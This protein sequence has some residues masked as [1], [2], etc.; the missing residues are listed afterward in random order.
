[1]LEDKKEDKFK[2][3]AENIDN[4]DME[5]E[6]VKV[7]H[8][9]FLILFFI[10]FIFLISYF[11]DGF[12]S[13]YFNK[14]N[15]V[16]KEKTNNFLESYDPI[17]EAN[18]DNDNDGISNWREVLYKT[19]TEKKNS[20]DPSLSNDEKD[21]KITSETNFTSLAARDIYLATKYKEKYS[22]MNLQSIS[23]SIAKNYEDL[24]YPKR[25]IDLDVTSNNDRVFIK[26]YAN[27]MAMMFNT[28]FI[29]SNFVELKELELNDDK[30]TETRIYQKQI[31]DMCKAVITAKNI[32]LTYVDLHKDFI[33]NCEFYQN[34][35]SGIVTS[36]TD[37]VK[38]LI[39]VK[40]HPELFK[41]IFNNFN[42]YVNKL[43]A[44]NIVFKNNDL[45]YIFINNIL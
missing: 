16:K 41:N 24:L 23:T 2:G 4:Y 34:I 32:P 18:N 20:V 7:K 37:N 1:M 43:K 38:G 26:N 28:I 17:K 44:D 21:E 33:Y 22:N 14:S 45:G 36:K 13:D 10:F 31:A 6:I 3:N 42:N 40:K 27:I 29:N 8:A 35:L 30:F 5:K 25:I 12:L 11:K 19:D 39:S 9:F 15:F